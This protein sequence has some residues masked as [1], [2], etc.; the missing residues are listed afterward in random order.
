M[1]Y[2]LTP[3]M[4]DSEVAYFEKLMKSLPDESIIA[5]WGSGGSTSMFLE[6]MKPNQKMFTIEHSPEWSAK[7]TE[8]LKDHRNYNNLLSINIQLQKIEMKNEAGEVDSQFYET[9]KSI[10]MGVFLEENPCFLDHYIDPTK[11][12]PMLEEDAMKQ[13]L[14]RFFEADVYLVD[15]LARGA[16]LA[17]I[18]TKAKKKKAKIYVH[19]WIGRQNQYGWAASLFS[20]QEVIGQ[21]LLKLTI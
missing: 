5:E 19:D 8:A 15:G 11:L 14:N 16:V 9:Y 13:R 7:V 1:K 4:H 21:S 6:L 18:R 17:T 12:M 3:Y 20:K 10:M 2:R